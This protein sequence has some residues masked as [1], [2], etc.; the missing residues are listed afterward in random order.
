MQRERG[1]VRVSPARA[2]V[3]GH[4]IGHSRSPDL[5]RAAYAV[6]GE[7]VDYDAHDLVEEQLPAFVDARRGD[8]AWRGLSV[9]MPLKSA[10]AACADELT[11]L[12]AAVGAVNTLVFR[13]DGTVLGHNT[14]VAGIVGAVRAA[15]P[16][17]AAPRAA[18]LGGGGTATAAVAA[19]G[20]LGARAVDVFVRSA[21]RAGRAVEAGRRLGLPVR[22]RAW[23][24]APA[25][26]PG[27][28]VVVC[29]LPP[30]GADELA[31]DAARLSPVTT[32]VLLDAAYDPWPSAIAR[33][34]AQAGGAVAPGIDMLIFQAV[35]QI[36][37]FTGRG[38]GTP[39]PREQDV[40]AALCTAVGRPVR[41]VP[42]PPAS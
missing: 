32:G 27:Y 31:R 26:L 34:W 38:P 12:G 17:P 3:V 11:E 40:V 6:L 5:H 14:D 33:T 22:L 37:L 1:P 29:T 42:P 2:A 4:P 39:L 19:A 8:P 18:V 10:A 21:A 24:E 9:T 20:R 41:D 30:H 13:P 25:A 28:D 7:A 35:D 16:V 15:G 36:R 23:D